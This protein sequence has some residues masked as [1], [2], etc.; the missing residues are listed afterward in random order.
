MVLNTHLTQLIVLNTDGAKHL[1]QLV[2]LDT[3]GAKHTPY[4]A[5]STQH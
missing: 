2:V 3:G 4:T 5:G 1:V